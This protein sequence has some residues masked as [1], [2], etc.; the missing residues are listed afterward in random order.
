MS[1]TKRNMPPPCIEGYTEKQRPNGAVCCYKNKTLPKREVACSLKNPKPPCKKGYLTRKRPNGAVCCY[2]DI[3]VKNVKSPGCSS[4]NPKP[5]CTEG[6]YTKQ[7]ANAAKCCY[8]MSVKKQKKTLKKEKAAKVEQTKKVVFLFLTMADHAKPEVWAKFLKGYEDK[9]EIV[10]HPYLPKDI[11]DKR[12]D[13]K[14]ILEKNISSFL[15]SKVIQKRETTEWGHLVK[16]Y[17]ALLEEAYDK[18]PDASRFVYLSNTCV[19][20]MSAKE[21]HTILTNNENVTF[22]D[23]PPE[24]R[25]N[26]SNRF[27]KKSYI[28][29]KPNQPRLEG[30]GLKKQHFMKHS[31]WFG[32]S[33]TH[34]SLLLK[35]RDLF[36]SLNHVRAGDEHILSILNL[37][38]NEKDNIVHRPITYVSWDEEGE[39]KWKLEYDRL[40]KKH[41]N[42]THGM[43]SFVDSKQKQI[44]YSKIKKHQLKGRV[45]WHPKSCT[46]KLTSSD[47]EKYRKAGYIFAR[48]IE[49]K[50]D[51]SDLMPYLQ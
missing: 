31:G 40:W 42:A 36:Y 10:C 49:S 33:N 17:Y 28:D 4:R 6:Y 14:K 47:I 22:F 32:L 15:C 16:A 48:K 2:R 43:S 13:G 39:K 21:A 5:P 38:D 1:C 23:S 12:V 11:N 20:I 29:G 27:T 9:F 26:D 37:Y 8:K 18:F 19:P 41:D 30:Y 46:T 35:N 44:I 7:R 34:A 45:F 24:K 25:N 50:C 3:T 51:V